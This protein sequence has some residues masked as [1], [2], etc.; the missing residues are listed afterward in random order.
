[1]TIT[2]TPHPDAEAAELER[3]GIT[4]VRADTYHVGEYRYGKIADAIAQAKRA[5]SS[6]ESAT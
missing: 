2:V 1:M 4:R 3:Y 5:E 6:Q